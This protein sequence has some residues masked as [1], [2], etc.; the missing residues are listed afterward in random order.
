[1]DP[2][3]QMLVR[4]LGFFLW[5]SAAWHKLRSFG[6][7]RALLQ[8]YHLPL[9]QLHGVLSGVLIGLESLL[10]VFFCWS[11]ALTLA[12]WASAALLGLYTAVLVRE[13][14]AGRTDHACGCAGPAGTAGI[15]WPLVWRNVIL[16]VVFL[17]A[18]RTAPQRAWTWFDTFTVVA[19]SAA[20]AVL[21]VAIEALVQNRFRRIA[22]RADGV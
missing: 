17:M 15:G 16:A 22:R 20:L 8:Q 4:I 3:Y 10:A 19:A 18:T 1:M 21:F 2:A 11:G 13:I 5:S 6:E 14:L 7:F 9:P 12:C